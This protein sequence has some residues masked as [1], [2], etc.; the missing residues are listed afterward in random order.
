MTDLVGQQFG[1]Y[2]LV[3][4]LEELAQVYLGKHRYLNSYAALKVLNTTLRPGMSTNFS[5]SSNP[6][7]FATPQYCTPARF[8]H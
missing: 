4:L 6:S 7:G 2:Q 8:C 5:R 1:N 3:N